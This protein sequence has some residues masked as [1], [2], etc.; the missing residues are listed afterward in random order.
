MAKGRAKG[1]F[2]KLLTKIKKKKDS[3]KMPEAL[4]QAI[5]TGTMKKR[6]KES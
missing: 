3:V 1:T 2:T 4:T 5:L 6:K